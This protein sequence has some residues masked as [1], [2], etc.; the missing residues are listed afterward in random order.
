MRLTVIHK[1]GLA[2]A[3]VLLLGLMPVLMIF[4]GLKQLEQTVGQVTDIDEPISAAAYE[5]EISTIG[6]G[7][8]VLK[9][10]ETGE[11]EYRAQLAKHEADF[12]RFKAQ[13]DRVVGTETGKALGQKI[14]VLY[15]KFKTLG[16]IL[17]DQKD[18]RELIFSKIGAELSLVLS[19][20]NERGFGLGDSPRQSIH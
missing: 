17:M 6:S 9:Y 18:E 7:M 15:Q 2:L 14:V 5:M 1:I 12:G 13:Y 10:L 20:L 19:A 4:N 16:K 3:V 8:A 11:A